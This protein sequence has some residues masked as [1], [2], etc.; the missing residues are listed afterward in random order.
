[1][2]RSVPECEYRL[3]KIAR[4]RNKDGRYTHVLEH[5]VVLCEDRETVMV[6][7]LFRAR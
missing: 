6:Y 3:M 1:M 2:T 5:E 7:L 4:D